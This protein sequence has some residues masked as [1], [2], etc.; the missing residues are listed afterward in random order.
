MRETLRMTRGRTER[1]QRVNEKEGHLLKAGESKGDDGEEEEK[2]KR[3]EG[4]REQGPLSKDVQ[5]M[6]DNITV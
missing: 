3:R 2:G 6:S 1:W 4:E 5:K